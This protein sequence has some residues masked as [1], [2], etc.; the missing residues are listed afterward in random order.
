MGGLVYVMLTMYSVFAVYD[1]WLSP[2]LHDSLSLVVR[3]YEAV[4]QDELKDKSFRRREFARKAF[5]EQT[6]LCHCITKLFQGG[7]F[8]CYAKETARDK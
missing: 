4:K 8:V 3:L 2:Y 6:G 5:R 1:A 7:S